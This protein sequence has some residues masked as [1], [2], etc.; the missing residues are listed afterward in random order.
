MQ[1]SHKGWCSKLG[2]I[3]SELLHSSR[4][5]ERGQ[6]S[7]LESTECHKLYTGL[8]GISDLWSRDT[9]SWRW[10]CQEWSMDKNTLNSLFFP[11]LSCR[12]YPLARGYGFYYSSFRSI[13]QSREQ[14]GKGWKKW[15]VGLEEQTKDIGD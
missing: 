8:Q 9:A 3:A 4:E 15:W 6:S 11:T 12:C 10:P 7:K 13:S 2:P 1:K 14:G 5:E